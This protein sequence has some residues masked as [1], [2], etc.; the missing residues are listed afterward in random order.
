[1]ER[2]DVWLATGGTGGH[3]FP[4]LAIADALL[5]Q[6]PSLKLRFVGAH[7][8]METRLVPAAGYTL[9][10]L[11]IRGLRRQKTLAALGTNLGVPL[12]ALR[13]LWQMR[14]WLRASGARLVIGTGGY[15]SF[16][17]LAAARLTGTRYV[18]NE[19]NAYPGLV[20]RWFARRAKAVYLGN[21]AAAGYLP[22]APTRVLGNPIRP[23]LLRATD[24]T[25]RAEA[26]HALG[27]GDKPTLLVVGG[28][29]GAG[30]LNAALVAHQAALADAH[31]NVLWQCGRRNY[32]SLLPEV[33]A[34]NIR[35]LP[36]IDDMAQAYA[37]ADVVVC[38]AG[39]L[40]LAELAALGKPAI[41]VPSPNVA[42]DH[43]T[44]NA[45]SFADLGAAW[46]VP[47]A[48]AL[49]ALVP[50]AIALLHDT[51]TQHAL[52]DRCRTLGA[53]HAAQ[54]IATDILTRVL[55]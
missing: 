39:A 7:G 2:I 41:L 13:S 52:A 44:A 43:Q 27:V 26:R 53:P 15:A 16:P 5:A 22:G 20:N 42:E 50:K 30:R 45:R 36:F 54:A 3:I 24:P 25:Y 37:A 48:D 35:L 46:L 23:E 29:L 31:V 10:T 51:A 12:L 17:A 55:A 4:A 1:M 19:Q 34:R 6:Q 21:A 49:D 33:T 38:R 32:D 9:H 28:S 14:A 11:P 18:L 40:T 8:G 47:D